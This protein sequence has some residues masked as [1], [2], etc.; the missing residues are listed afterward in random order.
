MNP[1]PNRSG[2]RIAMVLAA[3]VALGLALGVL[4]GL[5]VIRAATL[6]PDAW[7]YAVLRKG[8]DTVVR[9][10]LQIWALVLLP[11]LLRRTGW[12]GWRDIGWRDEAATV[13]GLTIG[14]DLLS[15]LALGLLTLGG[16][17]LFMKGQGWRIASPLPSD[18]SLGATLLGYAASGLAVAVI[19][20]TIARGILFRAWSR[21]WGAVAAALVSSLLFGLVHFVG[22]AREAFGPSSGLSAIWPVFKSTLA[23]VPNAP[24]FGL[25]LLN[26]SLLGL[27]LC[28]MVWRTRTVWLAVGAHAAWVW[29]IKAANLLTDPN[30]QRPWSLWW[31]TRADMTDALA[32]TVLMLVLVL[33]FVG[34]PARPKRPDA[35]R[36]AAEG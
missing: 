32:S 6:L 19:E 4:T 33:I 7:S 5:L 8:P 21:A 35:N 12:R 36:R 16:L 31:G 3:L 25:R 24:H 13:R 28:A 27:V 15:G 22:P 20:E 30:P 34:R 9:R 10:C 11:L 29:C 14:R 2:W 17:A 18:T 1:A 23:Q 26:L